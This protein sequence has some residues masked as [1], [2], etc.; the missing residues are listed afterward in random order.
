MV[1]SR[2]CVGSTMPIYTTQGIK[3]L[4][5]KRHVHLGIIRIPGVTKSSKTLRLPV[6]IEK[7]VTTTNQMLVE[8]NCNSLSSL[9][10]SSGYESL[11][12]KIEDSSEETPIWQISSNKIRKH[13]PSFVDNS[14]QLNSSGSAGP[15][16]TLLLEKLKNFLSNSFY[17]NLHVTG[18]ISRLAV[19]PQPLLRTYLLDDSL[20][21]QPNV[22][23]LFQVSQHLSYFII[24]LLL[25]V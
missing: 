21:L 18:L 23:S 25:F 3:F 11:K 20:V 15:F 16:L 5:A 13:N 12:I 19:Y 7:S 14:D 17:I 6:R 10:E 2:V 9:G 8:E 22:P 4:A 24:F 1:D